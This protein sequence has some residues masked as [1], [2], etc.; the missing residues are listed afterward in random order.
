MK[1]ND[2]HTDMYTY[3]LKYLSLYLYTYDKIL[4]HKVKQSVKLREF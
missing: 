2:R 4:P 3:S 1:K